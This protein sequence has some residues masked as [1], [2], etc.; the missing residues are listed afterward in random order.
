MKPFIESLGISTSP[1]II[2]ILALLVFIIVAK[3]ADILVS[4]VIRKFARFTKSD[5]DDKII[6]L[7]HRPILYSIVIIG[8]VYSITYLGPSEKS[9]FYFRGI[10]Y[11]FMALIWCVALVRMSNALIQGA[12]LKVSDVTSQKVLREL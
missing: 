6:D 4:T 1:L 11:T 12:L 5:I 8:S 7:L 9:Y 3:I 2:A 10:L